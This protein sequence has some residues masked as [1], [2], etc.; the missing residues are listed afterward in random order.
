MST[1]PERCLVIEDSAASIE[2]GLAAGMA[3]RR[4]T[5]YAYLVRGSCPDSR[6]Q[7]TV[8]AVQAPDLFL[9]AAR[10]MST[11]PERCLVI[12]DSAAGIEAGLAAGMNVWR[13]VGGS[14]IADARNRPLARAR[15]ETPADVSGF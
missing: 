5:P 13:Y 9:F 3:A 11:P 8:A 15:D 6:F 14:H 7:P 4:A 1:P 10:E 12:E 2:A